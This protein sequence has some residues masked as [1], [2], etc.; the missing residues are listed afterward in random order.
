MKKLFGVMMIG[1]L[2]LTGCA[3]TG[4]G[5]E[6]NAANI[7]M[8]IFKGVVDT[9]CRSELNQ[10]S[11]YQV[12][13]MILSETQKNNLENKICGCVS[14]KAPES[15]TLTEIAQAAIDPSARTQVVASAVGKTLNACV[16]DFISG[17]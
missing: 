8:N 7:G 12:A 15:V 1:A 11:V 14:D 5:D 3:G 6:L 10:Q 4:A 2:A 16:S 17:K 13:T 9:K